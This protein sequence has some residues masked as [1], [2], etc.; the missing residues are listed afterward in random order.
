MNDHHLSRE[1]RAE[2]E[3]NSSEAEA[4]RKAKDVARVTTEELRNALQAKG[5]Q[6]RSVP[7]Y[8]KGKKD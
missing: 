1:E 6:G 7:G 4:V 8:V 2:R 5:E 3:E